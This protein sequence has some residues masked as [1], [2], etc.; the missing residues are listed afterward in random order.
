MKFEYYS[1]TDTLYILLKDEPATEVREVAP[2]IVLDLDSSGE[3]VG[4]EIEHASTGTDLTSLHLSS[5][6]VRDFV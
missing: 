5:L 3:V 4:I 2:D 6:P 1:E